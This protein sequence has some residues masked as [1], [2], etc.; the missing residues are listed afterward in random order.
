MELVVRLPVLHAGQE[1]ILASHAKRKVIRAGRRF[2]KTW[3]A[4]DIA[5][6]AFLDGRRVLYTAPTNEQTQRFWFLVKDFLGEL[7]DSPKF[8]K[9]ETEHLIE[10]PNTTNRVRAKTAWNAD[11][12]RGDFADLIIFDE[13]QLTDENAWGL[14]GAPM[15]LDNDGDAIF[16]YTPPSMRTRSTSKFKAKDPMHAAKMF[17]RAKDEQDAAAATGRTPRWQTFTGSSFDNPTLSREALDS[18]TGDMSSLAYRQEILAEDVDEVPGALWTREIIDNTRISRAPSIDEYELIVVAVDPAA[19]SMGDEAGVVVCARK[20]SDFYIL[21]DASRQGSP[22]QWASAAVTMFY[23]YK[24]NYIIA[25]SNQGGEMITNVMKQVDLNAPV[26]LVHASRG[27]FT[28]AEPVSVVYYKRL[29][30]HVG[31]FQQLEDEM[32]IWVPGDAS[33]NRMDAMV[34]GMTYLIGGVNPQVY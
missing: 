3:L 21:E 7:F 19:T 26:V 11:T 30:H 31:I 32:C 13:W 17:K 22:E 34:W 8:Y 24:A 18:I 9:N 4:A 1:A 29:V 20:G 2:G 12:L 16:I 6:E 23:K 25:E 28:R 15:L 27:K 33:P 5:V 14:V 10:R